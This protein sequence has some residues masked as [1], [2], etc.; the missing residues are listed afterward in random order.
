MLIGLFSILAVGLVASSVNAQSNPPPILP[1]ETGLSISLTSSGGSV[2]MN[3]IFGTAIIYEKGTTNPN[4]KIIDVYD[5]QSHQLNAQTGTW[6]Q[7]PINNLPCVVEAYH[8]NDIMV[9]ECARFMPNEMLII[10]YQVSAQGVKVTAQYQSENPA[11]NETHFYK[12][13]E[14]IEGDISFFDPTLEIITASGFTL[15]PDTTTKLLTKTNSGLVDGI[16]TTDFTT[17]DKL[18]RGYLIEITRDFDY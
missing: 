18:K 12:L 7:T 16:I 9:L 13:V 15:Q 17:P 1:D 14:I 2:K 10:Q 6:S 5:I 3:K 4:D 8:I 11:Q